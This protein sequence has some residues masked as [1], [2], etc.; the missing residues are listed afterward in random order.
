MEKQNPK[1][2]YDRAE[3]ENIES[4]KKELFSVVESGRKVVGL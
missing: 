3:E 2:F 4:G 1:V